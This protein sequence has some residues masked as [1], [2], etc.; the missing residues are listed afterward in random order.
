MKETRSS[1]GRWFLNRKLSAVFV[2]KGERKRQVDLH[3][4]PGVP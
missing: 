4:R 2:A 1:F 3:E